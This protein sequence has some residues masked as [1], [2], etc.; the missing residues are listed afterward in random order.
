MAAAAANGSKHPALVFSTKTS[1]RAVA[2]RTHTSIGRINRSHTSRGD[3]A[4]EDWPRLT[5]AVQILNDTNVLIDDSPTI[6]FSDLREKCLHEMKKS[7]R[8]T[9]VVID[10]LQYVSYEESND[11]ARKPV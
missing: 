9:L 3:L 11:Q 2:H 8:L 4:D 10:S 1:S 6:S 5:H 7:G